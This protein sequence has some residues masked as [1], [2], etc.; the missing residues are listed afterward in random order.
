MTARAVIA[1]AIL[2][3]QAASNVAN[4]KNVIKLTKEFAGG[5]ENYMKK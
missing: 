1:S 4:T 5:L 2:I 3:G